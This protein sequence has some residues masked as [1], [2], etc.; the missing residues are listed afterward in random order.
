MSRDFL[1]LHFI[2]ILWGFTAVLGKLID[3]PAVQLVALR[4]GIAALALALILRRGAIVPRR[5][6]LIFV[7]T[8]MIIGLHWLLFFL[9]V[10]VANVSICMIG[11]A[12]IS[13]WTA[14]L[15]PLMIRARTLRGIDMIFGC[16]VIGAVYL[17]IRSELQYSGGFLIAIGSA[18]AATVFSII[19]G[20]F[21]RRF[22]HRVI[23]FYEMI[24]ACLL[25]SICLPLSG[26]ISRAEAD[27]GQFLLDDL[28]WLLILALACT[29]YSFAQYVELLNRLTVFTVNFANNLEPVYGIIL[30]ALILGDYKHLGPGFYGGATIILLAVIAYPLLNRHLQRRAAAGGEKFV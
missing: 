25:C 29:V 30:G 24:G 1:K 15:E 18:L 17:I 11:M 21:A 27:M 2:I 28:A 26:L 23:T 16:I 10:K 12:T 9:S 8:G 19:N 6:A 7:A 20:T 13:L 14:L 4:T 22:H 5:D 3:L